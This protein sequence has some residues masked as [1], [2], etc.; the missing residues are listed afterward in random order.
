VR[1]GAHAVGVEEPD[2]RLKILVS[3]PSRRSS[4]DRSAAEV[5]MAPD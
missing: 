3:K 1:I 4:R 5:V 2:D